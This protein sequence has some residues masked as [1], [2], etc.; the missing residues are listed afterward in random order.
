MTQ[1][2]DEEDEDD[3][4]RDSKVAIR[5]LAHLV[6]ENDWFSLQIIGL[7]RAEVHEGKEEQEVD[8]AGDLRPEFAP[9]EKFTKLTAR[10]LRHN[11][12]GLEFRERILHFSLQ[13]RADTKDLDDVCLFIAYILCLQE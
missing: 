8:E 3:A 2:E 10:L 11:E 4:E 7:C 12:A 5:P 13:N 1:P 6:M 9:G